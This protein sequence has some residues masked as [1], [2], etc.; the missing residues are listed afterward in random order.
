MLQELKFQLST[1][2]LTILT[3]AA[4]VGAVVNLG[5][6][7]RFRLPD[8]G[9]TWVDRGGHVEALY[10]APGSPG[11]K[12]GI[13]PGDRLERI[14]GV[15]IQRALD[16]PQI[17]SSPSLGAWSRAKYTI[18]HVEHPGVTVEPSVIVG[19]APRN[20]AVLY[21]YAIG[22]TYLLIGLFVYYRRGSAQKAQ[23]FFILCLTSFAAF[24]FHY[25]GNLDAFDTW[26]TSST[27]PPDSLRPP[28][29]CTSA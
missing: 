18:E 28:Y 26:S 2:I 15:L 9:I 24:S 17:L 20:P 7:H 1:A 19:E 16:V 11:N 22:A 23:H 8:D 21:Q 14:Q 5:Q 27:W 29:S 12:A 3:I 4:S 10:V 25:T 6:Y 13:H